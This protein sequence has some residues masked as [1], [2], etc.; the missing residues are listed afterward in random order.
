MGDEER[1]A[2]DA[3]DVRAHWKGRHVPG[4]V[5]AKSVHRINIAISC[6]AGEGEGS[7]INL[8]IFHIDGIS[9]VSEE[10]LKF[11]S[12]RVSGLHPGEVELSHPRPVVGMPL[13]STLR[14]KLFCIPEPASLASHSVFEVLASPPR[15]GSQDYPAVPGYPAVAAVFESDQPRG[16]PKM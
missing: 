7:S 12:L 9:Q 16:N 3:P 5:A 2:H 8:W 10:L 14:C 4:L 6:E 13:D 15:L 11:P 1:K